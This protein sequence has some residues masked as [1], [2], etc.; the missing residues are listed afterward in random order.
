[1]NILRWLEKKKKEI[2]FSHN[3]LVII[4]MFTMLID[5]VGYVLIKNGK[6][7]G[8]NVALYENAI[9][10]PSAKP[11]LMLYSLCRMVGRVS[12]PIYALLIVEG[13]RKTSNLFKYF[14]RILLLAIVSEIPFDLMIFNNCF[15]RDCLELQNVLFTYLVGLLMLVVVRALNSISGFLSVIPATFAIIAC[16]FLKTDYWLEGILLI[17]VF[18]MLRF[19]LNVKCLIALVITFIMSIE[20]YFGFGALSILFIYFYDEQKGYLNL[21]RI[22]YIFYPL[23]MLVLYLMLFFT[24]LE[25]SI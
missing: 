7:Y 24:Y 25:N 15:T 2:G 19:D 8:Y 14:I 10:L 4:A 23:H 11:W 16:Y 13:F 3:V 12:F 18:Y 21:H 9:S 20:R 22:H 5:H 17:Y 6:L 1:M